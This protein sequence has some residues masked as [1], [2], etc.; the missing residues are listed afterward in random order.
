MIFLKTFDLSWVNDH[1][2]YFAYL[3]GVVIIVLLFLIIKKLNKDIK[4][5][6]KKSQKSA[7]DLMRKTSNYNKEGRKQLK[8]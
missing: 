3:G 4:K 6:N 5:M 1:F 7:I 2:L 8:F